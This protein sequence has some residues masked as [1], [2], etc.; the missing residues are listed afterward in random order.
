MDWQPKGLLRSTPTTHDAPLLRVVQVLSAGPSSP[1]NSVMALEVAHSRV[2]K[3][4]EK[5][6]SILATAAGAVNK[7][8]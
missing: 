8:L 5:K 1:T 3:Q 6:P 7:Y 2:R 4:H